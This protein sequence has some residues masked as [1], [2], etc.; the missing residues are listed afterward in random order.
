MYL[1][2][3]ANA[4]PIVLVTQH[5]GSD[6]DK[7]LAHE[8]DMA[9]RDS[10]G[11]P[12]K[13]YT[14]RQIDGQTI[15]VDAVGGRNYRWISN[16][17]VIMVEYHGSLRTLP[18]PLEVVQA[19]LTKH[20]STLPARTLQELRSSANKTTW[21]KDEMDRRLW[22]CDKWFYQ[23]QLK[24]VDEK[25]TYEGSVKSMTVF[26]D[27]REKYYGINAMDEEDLLE[28]YLRSN[29]G[30]GIKSKLTEYKNWWTVHKGDAISIQ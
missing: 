14:P 5:S 10:F 2:G 28:S 8:L 7:W 9:F 25:K 26:L 19:Y 6:S 11:I 1:G 22:L 17:K 13:A 21:I 3:D 24:K 30:T 20:P 18:E 23:L 12:S 15:M 4:S 27:Y 29:N 16:N